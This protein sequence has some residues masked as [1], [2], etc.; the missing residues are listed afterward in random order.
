AVFQLLV[1]Q[2]N[3]Q[4]ETARLFAREI[5]S[6]LAEPSLDRL[7]QADQETRQNLRTL[8]EQLTTH[9]QVVT[10][11][12]V[13]DKNGHVVASD[14]PRLG[15]RL[16]T[17]DEFFG[18]STKM[19]FTTFGAFPFYSGSYQLAVPLVAHDARVG[20]L[21]IDLQSKGVGEM[22]QRMWNSLFS[23]ALIGLLC[24]T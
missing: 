13:I 10:S 3:D 15:T 5:A 17:P 14:N 6:A 8:I 9:S 19:R 24:I 2:A 12:S 16:R 7:L 4:K 21:L 20:Y 1:L 23:A 11:I 18:A 22:N